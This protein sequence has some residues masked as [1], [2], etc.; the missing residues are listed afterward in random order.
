MSES[1]TH[2]VYI[3]HDAPLLAAASA[4][5][6]IALPKSADA[7]SQQI[8]GAARRVLGTITVEELP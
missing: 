7:A 5:F 4:C 6:P 1:V 3:P 2:P 8:K